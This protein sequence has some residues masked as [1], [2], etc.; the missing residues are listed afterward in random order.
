MSIEYNEPPNEGQ[1][2]N[3]EQN[4]PQETLLKSTE[5][6][7]RPN[8][9]QNFSLNLF[10]DIYKF[11]ISIVQNKLRMAIKAEKLT[12]SFFLR[13]F[14]L[15]ELISSNK[16]FRLYDSI[17]DTFSFFTDVFSD[18]SNI[19]LIKENEKGNLVMSIKIKLS[20]SQLIQKRIDNILVIEI[21]KLCK[22]D[23]D[24]N[25]VNNN[26]INF[27]TDALNNK[28]NIY[29]Y[30]LDFNYHLLFIQKEKK[31]DSISLEQKE[32][33]EKVRT[34][35]TKNNEIIKN[36]NAIKENQSKLII[37]LE[38]KIN[39]FKKSIKNT[40]ENPNIRVYHDK[41]FLGKK[42]KGVEKNDFPSLL[43]PN[44]NES[45][46]K[47]NDNIFKKLY[48][49]NIK[50]KR[51]SQLSLNKVY[52]NKEKVSDLSTNY[53]KKEEGMNEEEE[54]N[55]LYEDEDCYKIIDDIEFFSRNKKVFETSGNE[56]INNSKEKM[57]NNFNINKNENKVGILNENEKFP[58]FNN[59]GY[60]YYYYQLEKNNNSNNFGNQN[61]SSRQ[62]VK[63]Y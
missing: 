25:I 29:N 35:E 14:L 12:T 50:R 40:L 52:E 4:V 61:M 46:P 48:E 34:L 27:D 43:L 54:D 26:F 39:N 22:D 42:K 19:S 60:Y 37:S 56:N 38:N 9:S 51:E 8:F 59:P 7:H 58:L 28:I 10:G 49:E 53:N 6:I 41:D 11:S 63:E 62:V 45:K 36:F 1:F 32:I 17:D 30:D 18:S 47:T 15:E 13:N 31:I 2:I 20:K 5:A 33:K 21:P 23:K 3:R 24:F 57:S 44:L 16:Y 55:Y